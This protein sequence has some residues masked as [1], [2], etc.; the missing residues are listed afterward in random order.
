[1][2][3][4]W[5]FPVGADIKSSFAVKM[6]VTASSMYSPWVKLIPE[7]VPKKWILITPKKAPKQ[8]GITGNGK[9]IKGKHN[10]PNFPPP[11]IS[12]KANTKSTLK[13]IAQ[14]VLMMHSTVK[15]LVPT[16]ITSFA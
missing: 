2:S 7:S 14:S 15:P 3:S 16:V 5:S 4:Y 11:N 6:S 1:L 12:F 10:Y 13:S 8:T 9:I